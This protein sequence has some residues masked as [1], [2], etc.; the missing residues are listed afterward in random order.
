MVRSATGT[1][2]INCDGAFIQDTLNGSWGLFIIRDRQSD[3]VAAAVAAGAGRLSAV[4][5]AL[6]AETSACAEALQS[7]IDFGIS[8]IQLKMDSSVFKKAFLSSSMDLAASGMLIRDTR[9]SLHGHLV[10]N[11]VLSVPRTNKLVV[12]TNIPPVRQAI[13]DHE[14]FTAGWFD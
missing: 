1:L 7:A 10:C 2:K 4:P 9:E 14:L 12:M 8:R 5:D 11:D 3:A 13:N 6:T